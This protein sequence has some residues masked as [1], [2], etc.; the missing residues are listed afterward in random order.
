MQRYFL[1]ENAE[2][3]QRFFIHNTDDIHHIKN[4]MRMNVEQKIILTFKDKKSLISEITA[5]HDDCIEVLTLED[6]TRQTELPIEVTIA[7]GL[8]KGDKYEWMIQKAT[9]MGAH[10]FIAVQSERSIVKLEEKKL[11]KKLERWQKIVKEA[12]EQSMRLTIPDIKYKSNFKGIYD[13]MNEYDYILIAYEEEAKRGETS[14]LHQIGSNL[15]HGQKIL[16][17]FGPEGGLT[18]SEVHLFKDAVKMSLGPRILR[19]ETAPLYALAAL[20]YQLELMR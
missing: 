1:L 10:H 12:S 17:I 2:L 8:I 4:V 3:N 6:T 13:N 11:H 19:A 7:S 5:Y 9:E 15:K 14:K 16:I 20:S 18:E